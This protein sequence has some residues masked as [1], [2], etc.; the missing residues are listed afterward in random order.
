MT[1]AKQLERLATDTD[2]MPHD[3]DSD[4][5]S[6]LFALAIAEAADERKAADIVIL[7][8]GDV[9]YLAD[10]F[11]IATGFSRAQVRAIADA[12]AERTKEQFQRAPL[13]VDGQSDRSWIVQDFGDT[14]VHILLPEEREYYDIEAFWGH[15]QRFEF[16]SNDNESGQ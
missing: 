14:I 10:Y 3:R 6:R 15:A 8:V 1:N 12:I 9:S 13:R 16:A 7:K 4:D 5:S 11:V 2:A